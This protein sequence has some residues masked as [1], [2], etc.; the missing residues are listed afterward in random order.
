MFVPSLVTQTG[1]V[2]CSL[3]MKP[4]R[5]ILNLINALIFIVQLDISIPLW[6]VIISIVLP[7]MS[8]Q[9]ESGS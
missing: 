4:I 6:S 9:A 8:A 2:P 3:H 5:L 7:A 1:V